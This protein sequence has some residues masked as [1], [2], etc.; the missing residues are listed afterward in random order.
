[1]FFPDGSLPFVPVMKPAHLRNRHDA[2]IDRRGDRARDRRVLVQRQV[3]ARLFVVSAIEFHQPLESR[4][5][6]HDDVIE[7]L[8]SRRSDESLDVR[9][10]PG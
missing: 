4:G 9:V 3:S 2:T 6:E 1:V 10:L 8:A 5:V 7:T